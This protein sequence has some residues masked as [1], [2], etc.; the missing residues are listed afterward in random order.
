MRARS[1]A[2]LA[3]P[4]E[5]APQRLVAHGEALVQLPHHRGGPARR[6]R[7]GR[8]MPTSASSTRRRRRWQPT[9]HAP[10]PRAHIGQQRAEWV[11]R[12]TGVAQRGTK[13]L[14][15]SFVGMRATR[16]QAELELHGDWPHRTPAASPARGGGPRPVKAGLIDGE[17]VQLE[18]CSSEAAR[19]SR[20]SWACASAPPAGR[21][22]RC[23]HRLG[24]ACSP[25]R[26][27]GRAARECRQAG[28]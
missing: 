9:P 19:F 11:H 28:N 26:R 23:R 1:R 27:L 24:P 18:D 14:K 17:A 10:Q 4:P 16:P 12:E 25:P 2:P 13:G 3:S 8:T 20:R 7:S 21:R 15:E 22:G 6:Q 5:C